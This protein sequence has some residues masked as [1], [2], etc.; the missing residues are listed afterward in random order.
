M[1][2]YKN[3]IKELN[4]IPHPEGGHFAETYRDPKGLFSYIYY[5]LEKKEKSHWHKLTKNEILHFYDGDPLK[6]L[7]S[8]DK[9]NTSKIVLGK[10][11][12]NNHFYNFTVTAGT[13]FSMYT[14]GDWSLI[15]C[16][17]APAFNYEDFELAPKDWE[18]VNINI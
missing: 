3:L 15:G 18:P 1:N 12:H 8:K 16:I 10:D 2:K 6:I 9:I 11:L 13:W 4:L 14:T 7:L 5:L 17:V